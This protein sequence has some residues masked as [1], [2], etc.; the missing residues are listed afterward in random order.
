MA[1]I[2]EMQVKWVKLGPEKRKLRE[3]RGRL[4][5]IREMAESMEGKRKKFLNLGLSSAPPPKEK[6]GDCMTSSNMVN[7]SATHGCF[8]VFLK[9][10]ACLLFIA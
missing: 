2:G 4:E 3:E 8:C 1:E 6:I 7:D 9:K 5:A 10:C